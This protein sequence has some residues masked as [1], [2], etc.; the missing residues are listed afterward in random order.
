MS[1]PDLKL[2]VVLPTR[3]VVLAGGDDPDAG[4]IVRMARLAE[5]A[6]VDSVWVGDRLVAKP[7]LEPLAALAAVAASTSRVRMGTS[8]L[9]A[10]LRHPVL[11]AQTAATVDQLSEGRLTLAM[12]VGGA[13]TE[14]Q[15]N[16]WATAGVEKRTRATRVEEIV[17]IMR[18]LWSGDPITFHGKHFDLDH[19]SIGYRPHQRPGVPIL[20]ATHSGQGRSRQPARAAK[21]SDGIISISDSPQEFA[22]VRADVAKEAE[23]IGRSADELKS[24]YYMTVNLDP[25]AQKG[26]EEGVQWVTDYYGLN[27]WGDRWGP[28]GDTEGVIDRIRQFRAAGADEVIVRFASYNQPRQM[29]WFATNVLPAFR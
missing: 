26:Q 1:E 20:L 27:F 21:L 16:E 15:Q 8:V 4:L 28:Y 17:T 12:G 11:L 23:T 10:A 25:D 19:V 7:R 6:G 13:F 3:G 29:N 9:L 2:G 18:G 5:D 14:E 22:G 24:V